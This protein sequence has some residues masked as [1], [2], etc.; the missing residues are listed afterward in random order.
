MVKVFDLEP[1]GLKDGGQA[2]L[3]EEETNRLNKE[4]EL[5]QKQQET[6][7]G[8]AIELRNKIA[9][10]MMRVEFPKEIIEEI[11]LAADF[12]LESKFPPSEELYTDVYI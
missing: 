3:N 2:K 9:C 1:G 7:K 6:N 4:N 11:K 5:K 12:A 8:L 10:P